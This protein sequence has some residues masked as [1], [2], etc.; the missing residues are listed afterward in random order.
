[1]RFLRD[2]LEEVPRGRYSG[3]QRREV[4]GDRPD[5]LHFLRLLR[6]RMP[7]KM[8]GAG[9]GVRALRV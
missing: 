7:E 4:L 5:A 6:R 1:M 2:M 9:Y 8:P 3:E